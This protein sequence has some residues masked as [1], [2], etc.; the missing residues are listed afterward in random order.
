MLKRTLSCFL[1]LIISVAPVQARAGSQG[2]DQANRGVDAKKAIE[3]IGVDYTRRVRLTLRNET[4]VEGYIRT[5][6]DDYVEVTNHKTAQTVRVGYA[7]IV[8]IKV[9]KIWIDGKRTLGAIIGGAAIIIFAFT[10]YA[11]NDK[12]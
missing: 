12:S 9:K 3:A 11:L 7:D 1:L 4:K 8:S 5:V 10:V 6:A 2:A